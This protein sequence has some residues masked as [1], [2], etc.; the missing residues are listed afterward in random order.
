M[1]ELLSFIEGALPPPDFSEANRDLDELVRLSR[2]QFFDLH[3]FLLLISEAGFPTFAVKTD[4]AAAVT[5]PGSVIYYQIGKPLQVL[6]AAMRAGDF[7]PNEVQ[8]SPGRFGL[9]SQE[10][11]ASNLIGHL[12]LSFATVG[13]VGTASVAKT[14]AEV[15]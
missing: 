10:A 3:G 15:S 4:E 6:L 9:G 2:A 7:D 8:N 1:S 13:S 5:A 14:G 11:L 12:D